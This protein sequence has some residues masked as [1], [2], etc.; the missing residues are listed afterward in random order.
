MNPIPPKPNPLPNERPRLG[1]VLPLLLVCFGV[2]SYLLYD[3]FRQPKDVASKRDE[4]STND[5]SQSPVP[6]N[7]PFALTNRSVAHRLAA[8]VLRKSVPAAEEPGDA[9]PKIEPSV[10]V[11]V[12]ARTT[13]AV[14]TPIVE[15]NVFAEITGRIVL[16]GTPPPEKPIPVTADPFCS[17]LYVGKQKP[18]TRFYV[19]STNGGLADTFIFIKEGMRS[20]LPPP[21]EAVVLDQIGCEYSP[22]VLGLQTRQKL[23]VKNSDPLLHNVHVVPSVSGNSEFNRA[24]APHV[25]PLEFTYF[26]PEIFLRFKCDLHPWMLAYVGIVDHPYFAVSDRDGYFQISNVPPGKFVFGAIHRKAGSADQEVVV[27]PGDRITLNFV[28][29]LPTPGS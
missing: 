20:K 21:R 29:E 18:T 8:R 13:V 9:E 3:L 5:F 4:A 25:A 10:V 22:Y 11:P 16:K 24:Q 2:T 15:A 19:V 28:F 27:K 14:P 17:K 7:E 12:P 6:A 26:H 1:V 23:L